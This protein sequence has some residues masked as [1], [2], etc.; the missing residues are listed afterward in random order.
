MRGFQTSR[1]RLG[2]TEQPPPH[3][4]EGVPCFRGFHVASS[5][6]PSLQSVGTV[7]A[8]LPMLDLLDTELVTVNVP[9]TKSNHC[10]N[11]YRRI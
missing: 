4:Q 11:N 1:A 2:V 3:L 5:E 8:R 7:F 6:T 10:L 9:G